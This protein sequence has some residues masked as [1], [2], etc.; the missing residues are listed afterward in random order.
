M[1]AG[2]L[3]PVF[4]TGKKAGQGSMKKN[5]TMAQAVTLLTALRMFTNGEYNLLLPAILLQIF[6]RY[7]S[8]NRISNFDGIEKLEYLKMAWIWPP[9]ISFDVYMFLKIGY[10]I[11]FF[12]TQIKMKYPSHEFKI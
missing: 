6:L 1:C 10:T 7:E 4:Q 12:T 3:I 2:D 9:K 5:T 11:N 8:L